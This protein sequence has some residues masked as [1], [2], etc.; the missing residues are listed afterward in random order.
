M[1][2]SSIR[3]QLYRAA[4]DMGDVQAA[5]RGPG[6]YARR[7]VR[8]RVYRASNNLTSQLLRSFG[9]MGSRRR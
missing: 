1:S 8:R 5:G 4:R 6:A 3:S 7:V 2:R 9:L